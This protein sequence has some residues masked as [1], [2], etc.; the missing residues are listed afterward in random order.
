[1]V[2]QAWSCLAED[3]RFLFNKLLTGG[4]R[5]GVAQ[6]T[7]AKALAKH[8]GQDENTIAFKLMGNW[9]P[10][11][12]SF[13]DL[14]INDNPIQNLS[15]PYPFYL[16][17]ALDIE[18]KELGSPQEWMAEYKWDGIRGQLIKRG[19]NVFLWSRGEEL[20]TNQFPEFEKLAQLDFDFVFDGEILVS[21][22]NSI[23]S[24][25]DLQKRL[26]RKKVS[27]KMLAEFPAFIMLY[28]LFE[29]DREDTRILTQ[30]ERRSKLES[31]FSKFSEDLPVKISENISFSSW[32]QLT[33]LRKK[34]RALNAEGLM[35]KS[36]KGIYKT[37][38]KKGDWYKW[39]VDPMTIDAVM[40]YA[41]RGHGR[42]S[43]L[44]SD[45]TFALKDG[46]ALVP[47][48]KAYSGLTDEEFVEITKF[49]KKNTKERFGPVSSVTPVLVFEIAFE[50]IAESKRHKS[51][52]ALRFPR[53]KRWRKDKKVNEINTLDDIKKLLPK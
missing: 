18:L 25:N 5:M 32:S 39:K 14:L 38:R 28:D 13:E 11:K 9:D 1:M 34:A 12:I 37:G 6:K 31:L 50:G 41:Q 7:I 16:A 45:F 8:L 36:T 42:R 48:A 46:D 2:I 21:K 49:V 3:E 27:K 44:Y 52:V 33:E 29:L 35:L 15:K 22:N 26:G 40:L 4:F 17:Y 43:N 20:I 24:F 47:F 30:Q 10:N 23:G 51:G 53:I 19:E